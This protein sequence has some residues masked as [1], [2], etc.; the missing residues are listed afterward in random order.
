M[1]STCMHYDNTSACSV[2][3]VLVFH[4]TD[5]FALKG[6]IAERQGERE[7]MQDDHV[8]MDDVLSDSAMSNDM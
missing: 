2:L 5:L 4:T 3:D 8:I 1:Q 6:Y 7:D